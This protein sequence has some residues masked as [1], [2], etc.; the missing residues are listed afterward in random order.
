MKHHK[1]DQPMWGKNESCTVPCSEM[2]STLLFLYNMLKLRYT[3][4]IR[5]MLIIY[6]CHLLNCNLHSLFHGLKK[7]FKI[8]GWIFLPSL[9]A[10]PCTEHYCIVWILPS[11]PMRAIMVFVS[12]TLA[13]SFT[14]YALLLLSKL[15]RQKQL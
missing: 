6:L 1:C 5:Y 15:P 7:P 9:V 3:L 4:C 11:S 2:N 10:L 13:Y 12:K 14:P 8:S